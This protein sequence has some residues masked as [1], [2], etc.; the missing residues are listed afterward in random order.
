MTTPDQK[1][2]AVELRL[3]G[4]PVKQVAQHAGVSAPT[5]IALYRAYI[6]GGWSAVHH[7]GPGRPCGKNL[8]PDLAAI[9]EEL[10]YLL[11]EQVDRAGHEVK[12]LWNAQLLARWISSRISRKL[13]ARGALRW[14]R[15]W[16]W[17]PDAMQLGVKRHGRAI[18]FERYASF[19]SRAQAQG[20]KVFHCGEHT[21]P[22]GGCLLFA[23]DLRGQLHWIPARLPLSD[24]QYVDFMSRL[25][26][27]QQSG[28]AVVLQFAGLRFT[29]RLSSWLDRHRKLAQLLS[30]SEFSMPVEPASLPRPDPDVYKTNAKE[31]TP[32]SNNY[33]KE[34]EAQS[35]EILR[36]AYAEAENPVML[37]SIGKD[38][39]VMLH[40]AAKA[41]YPAPI[42]FPLLH[43]DTGWKFREMYAFRDATVRKHQLRLIVYSNP[44][45]VARGINP[46]T[47]GSS[48]HTTIMKTQALT[49]ALELY[50][51][52]VAFGGARRDEEKSRA[53]ERIFSFRNAEHRW[54]PKQ[55]RPE[56]WNLYNA[57][58]HPGESIRVFPL[59]NWTELD[60][61]KYILD[62]NI[63]TVPLYF[64]APRPVVE[65]DGQLIV[66]DDERMPLH[67]G[68]VPRIRHVRFRTLGCYPLTGATPSDAATLADVIAEMRQARNSEREG[69]LID[70]DSAASMEKKKQE[71]YF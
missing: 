22:E 23:I 6:D 28:I 32:M 2:I 16:G 39:S 50:K 53:K 43:I 41:F 44:D 70:S 37:Y 58:K 11:P 8:L 42:P 64:S 10:Q 5:V 59:S 67:P 48:L 47:H 45:G 57:R 35:I 54:D 60:I 56:L 33:L 19:I 20:L 65:R 4:V 7:R 13:T 69:R 12:P 31:P 40:L 17:M 3:K 61:W 68:E 55:Q 27:L 63:A 1:R 52:D 26:Q 36:E 46:F 30:A 24:Q 62:E 51:F 38:S 49:Q 29:P 9:K 25:L 15:N 66:V 21:T 18:A 34:L 71:G 14:L